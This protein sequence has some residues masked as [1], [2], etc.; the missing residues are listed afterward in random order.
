MAQITDQQNEDTGSISIQRIEHTTGWRVVDF[1]EIWEYRDLFYFLVYRDVKTRYAQS[2]L[3]IG[4]AVAQPIFMMIVFSVI[5]GRL[6]GVGSDGLPYVVFSYTALVPWTY[7]SGA[8]GA[9]TGSL[10]SNKNL[11]SKVYFPRLII[12]LTS[13]LAKLV[14]FLIALILVAVLM[15][16][17]GIAPSIWAVML[18]VYVL[19]M[20][21]TVAGLGMWLTALSVQFRDVSYGIPL[22]IQLLMYLSPVVYP[23]SVVPDKFRPYYA[24]NPMSAVIDGFRSGLLGATEPQF[25]LL[26]IGSGVALV[27][28]VTGAMYF[29]RTERIFADVV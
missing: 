20:L 7:F 21:A 19:I 25:D 11:L 4:W 27:L 28:I 15:I 23:V 5:F 9:S 12:P 6:V 14:D 26:L 29:K 10:T 16:W 22:G 17:Y 1:R 18:P 8:L 13:I 24:L 2:V 3:G